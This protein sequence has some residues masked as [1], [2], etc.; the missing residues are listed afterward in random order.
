MAEEETQEEQSTEQDP[1]ELLESKAK[2]QFNFIVAAGITTFLLIATAGFTYVSLSGRV[3][4]VTQ[5]PLMEMTNLSRLVSDEYE[6]LNLAV[7][8]HN[9]LMETIGE[10]LHAIDPSVDQ[11]KFAELEQIL[12]NQEQDYQ[13]FLETSKIAVHGL[14]EM[15]SGS[16]SWRE[17][18]STKLD[19][20][21]ATS[22]QREL[23]ISVNPGDQV[24]D[25]E[26]E[27]EMEPTEVIEASR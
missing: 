2:G 24:E 16:R 21:I 11:A 3:V 9:H 6:S 5:E 1:L 27:S 10:R 20:A 26:M 22:K 15:I 7:E 4:T 14:A 17:D 12:L 13:Y 8:F 18:F 19:I 23:N 25:T